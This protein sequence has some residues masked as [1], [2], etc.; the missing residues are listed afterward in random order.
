MHQPQE[1]TVETTHRA[2]DCHA[3][4]E[5]ISSAVTYAKVTGSVG[6]TFH[7]GQHIATVSRARTEV[8]R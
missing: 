7:D 5:A 3:C 2:E 8:A 6:A 1:W 4:Q